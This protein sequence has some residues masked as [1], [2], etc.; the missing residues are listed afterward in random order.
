MQYKIIYLTLSVGLLQDQY[1]LLGC[2]DANGEDCW[3][4]AK[5]RSTPSFFKH[6]QCTRVEHT[7]I[8]T[9]A[10]ALRRSNSFFNRIPS[11]N[12]SRVTSSSRLPPSSS[13]ISSEY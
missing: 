3:C 1:I 12:C 7:G 13:S 4:F 2:L 10:V 5:H 8:L 11:F 9:V 6:K